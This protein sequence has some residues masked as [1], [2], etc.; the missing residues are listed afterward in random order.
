MHLNRNEGLHIGTHTQRL[1][2]QLRRRG[3]VHEVVLDGIALGAGEGG[4]LTA[5][6]HH[7]FIDTVGHIRRPEELQ[8]KERHLRGVAVDNGAQ[9]ANV[10]QQ[11]TELRDATLHHL[12][13]GIRHTSAE[14]V[15]P[16]FHV[17]HTWGGLVHHEGLSLRGGHLHNLEVRLGVG[18]LGLDALK[19]DRGE[20]VEDGRQVRL[21]RL[22]VAG[23]RE[24]FEQDSIGHKVETREQVTLLLEVEG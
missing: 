14:A 3:E 18:I 12:S 20:T 22:R 4:F 23:L 5:C 15:Q 2:V 11:G 16:V 17:T 13:H 8:H 10:V 21:N 1:L 6:L 7:T 9:V 19:G 24:N